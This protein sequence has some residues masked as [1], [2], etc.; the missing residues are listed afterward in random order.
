MTIYKDFDFNFTMNS[1]GELSILTDTDAIK[2]ALRNCILTRC[3][4]FTRFQLPLFGSKIYN[5]LGE[6]INI[7]SSIQI[8]DE[9]RNAVQNFEHRVN[10]LDIIVSPNPTNNLYLVSMRYQI[11]NLNIID[12]VS[13]SVT[14]L[15]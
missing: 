7:V 5:F 6:K 15:K 2:Q 3:R 12:E 14:I 1:I 11:K 9:V 8:E 10:I 13:I 4:E